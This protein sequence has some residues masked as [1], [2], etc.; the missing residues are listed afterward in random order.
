MNPE[1]P[2]AS[3]SQ[4]STRRPATVLESVDEL[5]Q[6]IARRE[7]VKEAA[8]PAGAPAEDTVILRPAVRPSMAILQVLDDDQESGESIRIRADRF[9]IGRSD[10][11]LVIPHDGAMSGRHAEIARQ[12]RN[13]RYVWV[14]KDLQS[15]NGTFVRAQSVHL[16]DGQELIIGSRR[17]RFRG[18]LIGQSG[19]A[20]PSTP[21]TTRK[22]SGNLAGDDVRAAFAALVS[23]DAQ[24]DGTETPLISAEYWVGRDPAQSTI[25]LDDRH[26]S[27]RHARLYRNSQG[28]WRLQNARSLNGIWVRI[29]EISV[30]RGG[31]FLCGEQRFT[32]RIP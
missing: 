31:H 9:V 19:S 30:D 11:D 13:G 15:S 27:P 3:A 21:P 22:W 28:D 29:Q 25:V 7:T 6:L 5:R 18:P 8:G 16:H 17:Y 24:G 4:G 12:L 14:L 32:I 2:T 26:V 20:P 1:D 23:L 10:G